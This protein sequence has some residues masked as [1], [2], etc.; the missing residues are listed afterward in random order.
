MTTAS[1]QRAN[2]SGTTQPAVEIRGLVKTFGQTK[3]LDGLDLTVAP[4]DISGFLGPNGAGKSTTIR[5][6]LGLLRAEGGTVRLLGGD[7][8]RDAVNLHRRIAY[9]PGDVTLWPNLTGLQ[10]IDF[11]ARLRGKEAVDT[12]R[13]DEL[14]ERFELDPHKKARTY[15]KGNRQKVAIVAAFATNAELYILDEPTSGLD[16]LMEKA[17]QTCVAEVAA[18]GAAVLLSSHILAEVEELC[19]TVTI[20]RAGRAV[21]SGTLDQLRHLMRTTVKVR[22][23]SDGQRLQSTPFVHDFSIDDGHYV[24]SVDRNDLDNA[25]ALL[26]NLGIIDLTVT[27]ASLEDMFLREYQGAGR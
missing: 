27:P 17:F 21:R 3:A 25:M 20:I 6:L 5:V 4:G 22:T 10:A 9:V 19:K 26:T 1:L 24:F 11:L 2:T 18:H 13:R 14:I 12:R 8:W 15:S 16:P 7:P 23:H